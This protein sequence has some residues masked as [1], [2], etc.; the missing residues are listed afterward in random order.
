MKSLRERSLALVKGHT[1]ERPGFWLHTSGTG[2]S[3]Y[4]DD[5]ADRLGEWDERQFNDYS[6]VEELTTLPDA[7]FHR[8]IDQIV[9]ETA[10]KYGNVVKTALVCPPTI[11]GTS[12]GLVSGRGRQVYELT[13]TILQ[14]GYAPLIG[15]GQ[16]RWDNV[17]VYDLSDVY[18]AL[19]DVAVRKNPKP[20]D[21]GRTMVLL[22]RQW[23]ARLG[24][25]F[26][27]DCKQGRRSGLHPE[28]IP[29]E[30]IEQK[31]RLGPLR[32][33]SFKLGPQFAG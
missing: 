12:R 11:Y 16:A 27:A 25:S 13:K 6:G 32:F 7:A 2:I 15:K 10:S 8:H 1:P 4:F 26:E 33:P 31:R 28:G 21:L 3:T 17:R 23:P 19:V 20:G 5:S 18:L 9:L 14:E 30:A 22:R 29:G 24:R